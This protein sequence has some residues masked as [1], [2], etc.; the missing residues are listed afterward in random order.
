MGLLSPGSR[1]RLNCTG[2]RCTWPSAATSKLW[3]EAQRQ[4]APSRRNGAPSSGQ[5]SVWNGVIRD[6]GRTG[7]DEAG[8]VPAARPRRAGNES[9]AVAAAFL[10]DQHLGVDRGAELEV[11]HVATHGARDA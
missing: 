4:V 5:A 1:E 6:M 8:I 9:A 2:S 7:G 3:P 11:E 10:A